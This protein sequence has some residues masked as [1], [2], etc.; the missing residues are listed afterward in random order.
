MVYSVRNEVALQ[1]NSIAELDFSPDWRAPSH[2]HAEHEEFMVVTLGEI[3]IHSGSQTWRAEEGSVILYPRSVDHAEN[4]VN[5]KRVHLLCMSWKSPTPCT[6]RIIVRRDPHGR[7]QTAARWI[8]EWKA[9]PSPESLTA[10]SSLMNS[11]LLE[12]N[13]PEKISRDEF[14]DRAKSYMRNHLADPLDLEAVS[15]AVGMSKCHFS[16]EFSRVTGCSP[17]RFLRGLRVQTSEHLI[18]MT[19]MPL[20]T[21]AS[22]VGLSDEYHFSR[23]FHRE[24]GFPPSSMRKHFKNEC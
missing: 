19:T 18:L 12:L 4:S 8:Q 1:V 21:I 15:K 23:V 11:I 24:K 3:E 10:I 17:M 5:Q 9:Q 2:M 20:R 22:M 7:I 14:V 6:D 16:A 13:R